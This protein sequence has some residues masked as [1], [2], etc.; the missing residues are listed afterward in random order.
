MLELSLKI[1]SFKDIFFKKYHEFFIIHRFLTQAEVRYSDA[2]TSYN[3][4]LAQLRRRTGIDA[5]QA[6]KPQKI[7]PRESNLNDQN[8]D[9]L[10]EPFPLIPACEATNTSN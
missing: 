3:T 6:C 4:S 9:L 2:I 1:S 7:T 10:I 8:N 5:L